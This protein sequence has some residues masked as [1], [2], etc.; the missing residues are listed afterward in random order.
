MTKTKIEWANE[1]WNPITGCTKVSP[2]CANCYAE[3]M[4]TRLQAIGQRGY[5]GV[6]NERGHWTGKINLIPEKLDE[7]LRW[8]KPRRVFVNSMSDLFHEDVDFDYIRRVWDIM[9]VT[10]HHTYLILTKRAERMSA[11]VPA[12]IYLPN[13]WLGVSVE[14]QQRADE[15]IPWLLKTP[16]AVRFISAEPLLGPVDLN[17]EYGQ[18]IGDLLIDN[19]DWV[20]VGGESGPKA[21]P[22]QLNWAR[23][24]RDQCQGA[25]VAFNF[26]QWGEW[27]PGFPDGSTMRRVGK[28]AAGRLLDGVLWDEYPKVTT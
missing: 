26:K 8:K 10:P 21:R 27:L 4:S 9:R 14:D 20:I 12:F 16:A 22:M 5:D 6:V 7:P 19:L 1:V 17:V 28:K 24:L 11:T 23:S 3:R 2:G 25:G 13:V 18:G 15:R